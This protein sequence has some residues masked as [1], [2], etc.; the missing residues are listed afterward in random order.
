MTIS[1]IRAAKC[2]DT[3]SRTRPHLFPITPPQL[4]KGAPAQ[5]R[6]LW[7]CSHHKHG[8][9]NDHAQRRMEKYHRICISKFRSRTTHLPRRP[10][11]MHDRGHHDHPWWIQGWGWGRFKSSFPGFRNSRPPGEDFWE[12]ERA[13]MQR[14]IEQIKKEIEADPYGALFGRRL[15]PWSTFNKME[16]TFASMCRSIFGF[17]KSF[18]DTPKPRPMDTT[19]RTSPTKPSARSENENSVDH[20]KEDATSRASKDIDRD[21]FEFDP[22]SGRMS[23]RKPGSSTIELKTDLNDANGKQSAMGSSKPGSKRVGYLSPVQEVHGSAKG[24]AEADSKSNVNDGMGEVAKEPG[25]LIHED[26]EISSIN[27]K[28]SNHTTEH[29]KMNDNMFS[30]DTPK[31]KYPSSPNTNGM[32]QSKNGISSAKSWSEG[33]LFESRVSQEAQN[34]IKED[35]SMYNAKDGFRRSV[36][37]SQSV[38]KGTSAAFTPSWYSDPVPNK[39]RAE[40]LDLL[41]ASDIRSTYD[42]KAPEQNIGDQKRTRREALNESFDSHTDPEGEL[43]AQTIRSKFQHYQTHDPVKESASESP[44]PASTIESSLKATEDSTASQPPVHDEGIQSPPNMDQVNAANETSSSPATTPEI[45]HVLAYDPSTFQMTHA[46]T[47]SSTRATNESLHPAEVLPLLNN[48]AKFMPYISKMHADG[49]EIVSGSGDVLVF[50]RG[51]T[52]PAPSNVQEINANVRNEPLFTEKTG[53]PPSEGA[54]PPNMSSASQAP[55]SDENSTKSE[56]TK[57][58]SKF[59][60]TVRRM[61]ISGAATAGTCY[62]IGVVGEYFRTGGQDGRGIDGFTEFE[63]ERRQREREESGLR[64]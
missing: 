6:S 25:R 2:A 43:D 1:N 52:H 11:V 26:G 24:P 62:A 36:S 40:D 3:L 35:E 17:D 5:Y 55:S 14:R 30:E 38:E 28:D 48:P 59:G 32:L 19:G 20:T 23:P 61:F 12:A 49:Y 34:V 41:S 47:S 57:N 37:S 31:S 56:S 33:D 39:D 8:S 45:Y 16:S 44:S 10:R 15:E 54:T 13:R 60:K 18:D 7:R 42:S 58:E 64:S 27:A 22:I 50:R 21:D 51:S 9:V 46:E 29:L 63:S 4:W 53:E